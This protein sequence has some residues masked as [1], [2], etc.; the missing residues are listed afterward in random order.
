MRISVTTAVDPDD[1]RHA[2]IEVTG[3]DLTPDAEEAAP[4]VAWLGCELAGMLIRAALA[5][6]CKP[7][8]TSGPIPR[9]SPVRKIDKP[10]KFGPDPGDGGCGMYLDVTGLVAEYGEAQ[11]LSLA[12]PI[13]QVQMWVRT[14][15]W[16][17]EPL[18]KPASIEAQSRSRSGR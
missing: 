15:K 8:V 14:I 18:L 6:D 13:D 5:H 11:R 10:D 3:P 2:L 9:W 12:V 4:V 17:L 7:H 16:S 1:D